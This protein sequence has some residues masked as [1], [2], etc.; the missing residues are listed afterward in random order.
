MSWVVLLILAIIAFFG[1]KGLHSRHVS[2]CR[3][4][5]R[6]QEHVPESISEQADHKAFHDRNAALTGNMTANMSA[7]TS[8]HN[9][10]MPGE[11]AKPQRGGPSLLYAEQRAEDNSEKNTEINSG[12]NAGQNPEQINALDANQVADHQQHTVGSISSTDTGVDQSTSMSNA[13]TNNHNESSDQRSTVSASNQWQQESSDSMDFTAETATLSSDEVGLPANSSDYDQIDD[14]IDSEVTDI[15]L[16]K[17][18]DSMNEAIDTN[19]TPKNIADSTQSSTYSNNSNTGVAAAGVAAAA[20][21][22]GI[23]ASAQQSTQHSASPSPQS[24][25]QATAHVQSSADQHAAQISEFDQQTSAASQAAQPTTASAEDI[26]L[27]LGDT[28]LNDPDDLTSDE[29]DENDE[30]LDFGDLTAD[31]SE[32]LKELNLRE[33][34][35]PRLEINQDEFAQLKTGEPGEV[36]PEKIENV[37]GKLRNMLQ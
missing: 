2:R 26:D 19:E 10:G 35:S 34:D 20:A 5:E 16:D 12:Q 8:T 31:I 17:H 30:L 3:Y 7:T 11:R 32:M 6:T 36:K 28:T 4:D 25:T 1:Y 21:G 23:A 14:Q 15:T 24:I 22:V 9:N 33:A 18:T 29:S 37:A 27:E 13:D